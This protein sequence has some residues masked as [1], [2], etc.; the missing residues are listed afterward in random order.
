[1]IIFHGSAECKVILNFDV[2]GCHRD[3]LVTSSEIYFDVLVCRC[4][5]PAILIVTCVALRTDDHSCLAC[6]LLVSVIAVV[7]CPR[8]EPATVERVCQ[9][10]FSGL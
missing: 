1:M 3:V 2:V 5:V 4:D 7:I 8:H 10:A 9:K 6:L